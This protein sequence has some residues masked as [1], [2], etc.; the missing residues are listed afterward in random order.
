[1]LVVVAGQKRNRDD[2]QNKLR[3]DR[4]LQLYLHH[5]HVAFDTE[6]VR[7]FFFQYTA[8]MNEITFCNPVQG[9]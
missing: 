6:F 4:M 7:C 8:L 1:M 2:N 5:L 9:V 3:I